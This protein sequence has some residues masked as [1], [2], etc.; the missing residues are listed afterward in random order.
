MHAI[1]PSNLRYSY[2]FYL[3]FYCCVLVLLSLGEL[4]CDFMHFSFE[5]VLLCHHCWLWLD[6]ICLWRCLVNEFYARLHISH[7]RDIMENRVGDFK[8]L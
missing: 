4:C 5:L 1:M 7:I 8:A 6:R 2:S 3:C